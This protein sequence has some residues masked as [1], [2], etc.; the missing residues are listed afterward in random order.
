VVFR[1]DICSLSRLL[2]PARPECSLFR[3][4]SSYFRFLE[5][6]ASIRIRAKPSKENSFSKSPMTL[7]LPTEHLTYDDKS[8]RAWKG[9]DWD[10][11]DRLHEKG[12]ITDPR[13]KNKSV[14]ITDEGASRAKELFEKLFSK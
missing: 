5:D 13:N 12:F 8:G 4:L 11:L 14:V 7:R 2:I 1:R 9:I 10:A 3:P 6:R